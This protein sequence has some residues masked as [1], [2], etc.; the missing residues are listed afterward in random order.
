MHVNCVSS[1]P[2]VNV[3]LKMHRI[4]TTLELFRRIPNTLEIFSKYHLFPSKYFNPKE[5]NA[6]VTFSHSNVWLAD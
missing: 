5:M 3:T 6:S 1:S 4:T 2:S